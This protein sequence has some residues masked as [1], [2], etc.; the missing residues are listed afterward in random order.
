[1]NANDRALKITAATPARASRRAAWLRLLT[2]WH[3]ISSAL[4]LV[5][6]LFFA[7][8][9]ITLNHADTL[10][11]ASGQITRLETRL[12]A[13]LMHALD[14][15][16]RST[17]AA[18][19]P[20]LDAWLADT[21]QLALWPKGIEWSAD[22]IFVDLKRPGVDASL[23]IDRHRGVI[24]YEAVDRG[25][26]AWLDEL[27]RGRN[28]GPAW[29]AFITVFGI[30]CVIFSVTGLLLLQIHARSRWPVWPLTGLGLMAPLLLILLF[31]H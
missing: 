19:P 15:A 23:S 26:I 27:H 14:T 10:E 9:G 20:A 13:A 6:M 3:W 29:H 17:P 8:T 18:L 4:S 7:A 21:W 2:Q 22:E 11:S 1:M 5:G 31:I 30:A 25:W 16:G 28:A 12:P 24:R